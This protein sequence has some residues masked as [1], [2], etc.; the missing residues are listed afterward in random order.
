MKWLK[1]VLITVGPRIVGAVAGGVA[2]WVYAK[3][4]GAVTI[5]A[6]QAAEIVTAGLVG[7]AGLH[8]AVSSFVNSGDAAKLRVARAENDA[9]EIGGTV[10]V[11]RRD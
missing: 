4:R 10:T 7:Y 3:T 6:S 8:R 2:S 11:A 9:V 5:D 1:A